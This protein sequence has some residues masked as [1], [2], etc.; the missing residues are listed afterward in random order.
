LSEGFI[1]A[2]SQFPGLKVI[3]RASSFQ[4][5]NSRDPVSVIGAKLGVAH[6]LEGSVQ[7]AGDAVRISADLINAKDGT[8]LWSQR[9]DRPYTDLFKLQDDITNAVAA[10]LKT[11][12]L[13]GSDAPPPQTDRPPSGNLAAYNAYLQGEF[14]KFRNT[15]ADFHK[16]IDAFNTAIRIEP[17]YA[18]AYAELSVTRLNWAIE[19]LDGTAQQQAYAQARKAADAALAL[20]PALAASHNA[21][22]AVLLGVDF[23]WA[24]A[25]AEFRRA[26]QLDPNNVSAK[27]NLAIALAT[28]GRPDQAAALTRQAAAIDPLRAKSYLALAFYLLPLGRLDEAEQAIRKAIELQPA[29]TSAHE[30]LAVIEIR[31]GDPKSA[32]DAARAEPAGI[33][34][35]V[36]MAFALQIGSDRA[37]ADAALK[38][39]IAKYSNN[40]PYQIAETYA[41]RKDPDEMFEWLE[42]ART[43]HD[44]G[45][46]TL[47]YD[48]FILPY[49]HD[50]RFAALCKALKLPL[51]KG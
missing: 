31:R 49:R 34:H 12:L 27:G 30:F 40:G 24:G 44:T 14:Y 6:L 37:A 28:Q 35:D 20:A 10:A 16:A 5:R 26:L 25:E 11:K 4:F 8:T 23:N 47:L 22:G 48:A 42:R 18:Q 15:E 17:R 19:F 1:N 41:L 43:L 29:A 36:A 39:L 21:R 9:Y 2:L 3:A 46:Q 32:L 13:G 50:P 45:L 38:N 51:P 33:W 7:R